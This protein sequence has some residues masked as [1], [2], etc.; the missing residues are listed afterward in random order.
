AVRQQAVLDAYAGKYVALSRDPML[1]LQEV[2]SDPME[3]AFVREI[4]GRTRLE[5]VIDSARIPREK[6]RLLLVAL[7]QAG[8]IEPGD[9]PVRRPETPPPGASRGAAGVEPWG[10]G[11]EADG[12]DG[13]DDGGDTE[14]EIE[15]VTGAD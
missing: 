2:T 11:A 6:A 5:T 8:M 15:A 9:A 12:A 3:Q 4:D 14:V 7:S 13:A 1:R 10:D